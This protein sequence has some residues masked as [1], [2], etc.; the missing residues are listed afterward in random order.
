MFIDVMEKNEE[1]IRLFSV[2][3]TGQEGMSIN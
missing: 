3:L 1:G 2:A